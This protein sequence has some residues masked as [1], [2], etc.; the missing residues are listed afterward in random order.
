[1]PNYAGLTVSIPRVDAPTLQMFMAAFKSLKCFVLHSGHC[2][3]LVFK[4][5]L[6]KIYPHLEQVLDDG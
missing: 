6:S 1:L 2:H 3:S 4:S 5:N